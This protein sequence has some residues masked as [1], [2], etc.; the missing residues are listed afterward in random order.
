MTVEPMALGAFASSALGA[1]GFVGWR[2]STTAQ[3]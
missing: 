3:S 2:L 1:V